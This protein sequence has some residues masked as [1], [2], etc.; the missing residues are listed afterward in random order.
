MASVA[1][2]TAEYD[3][4]IRKMTREEL[5]HDYITLEESDRRISEKIYRH[6]HPD[7]AVSDATHSF[8]YK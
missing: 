5:E 4:R 8:L 7:F 2:P 6:F 1:E 3:F